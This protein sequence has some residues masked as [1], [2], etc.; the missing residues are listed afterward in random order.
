MSNISYIVQ[1]I[2]RVL[3][4][5][6]VKNDIKD[7]RSILYSNPTFPSIKAVHDTLTYYGIKSNVYHA[8]FEHIKDKPHSVIHTNNDGGHFYYI[9]EIDDKKV[10]LYDGTNRTIA[11]NIFL[12]IWDGVVLLIEGKDAIQA[13]SYPINKPHFFASLLIVLFIIEI[14]VFFGELNSVIILVL[15]VVGFALSYL[16]YNQS[17]YSFKSLPF[18]HLGERI[19][20]AIVSKLNPLKHIIPFGLPV[21]GMTFFTFDWLLLNLGNYQN[22]Y[23]L[24]LYWLAAGVMVLLDAYQLFIIK[25]I[26]LYCLCISAMVIIKPFLLSTNCWNVEMNIFQ[27][28]FAIIVSVIITTAIYE[29]G[30]L[31]KKEMDNSLNLLSIKRSPFVFEMILNRKPQMELVKDHALVFG[32][33]N[34]KFMFDTIINL[35]CRHCKIIVKEI[36]NLLEKYPNSFCWRVYIDSFFDPNHNNSENEKQLSLV[37]QYLRNRN[38]AYQSL[39]EWNFYNSGILSTNALELY[40]SHLSDIRQIGIKYYPTIFFNNHLFPSEY[41][42]SDIGILLNDWLKDNILSGD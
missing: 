23:I 9:R 39:K 31:L 41:E 3:K 32:N 42:I 22:C 28:L 26:C 15:D 18:C 1:I 12:N 21:V 20:C 37:N 25:K 30:N 16:M 6:S 7:T 13:S 36:C 38:Q 14:L 33:E 34:A 24:C 8:D 17:L 4:H 10:C 29:Y 35:N 27:I 5:W 19:D 11:K 40:E 2:D